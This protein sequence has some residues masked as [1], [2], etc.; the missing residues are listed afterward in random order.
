MIRSVR[1]QAALRRSYASTPP[2]SPDVAQYVDKA[3]KGAQSALAAAQKAAGPTGDKVVRHASCESLPVG[4]RAGKL[5]PGF[6]PG[7]L[8]SV[9]HGRRSDRPAKRP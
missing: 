3:Q 2:S 1:F 5:S 4:L 7:S 9:L 6:A 8:C